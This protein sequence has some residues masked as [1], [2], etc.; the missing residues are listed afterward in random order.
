[1]IDPMNQPAVLAEEKL[2]ESKAWRQVKYLE[3]A[4]IEAKNGLAH[5]KAEGAREERA[6]VIAFLN[7]RSSHWAVMPLGGRYLSLYI[8][9]TLGTAALHIGDSKHLE[10][11]DHDRSDG[12]GE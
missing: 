2:R 10:H 8:A 5:A 6:R 1:V 12:D 3:D 11:V 4:L 9:H 7:K